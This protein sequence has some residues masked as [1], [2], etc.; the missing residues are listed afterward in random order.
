M[1]LPN[2]LLKLLPMWNYICPRCKR[3]VEKNSRRCP[4]CA[5]NYG[6][7]LRVPPKVLKDQKAL[8][9]YVHKHVFPKVS[10]WQKAYLTQFFTTIFSDGFESG[11]FSAWTGTNGSPSVVGSPVH[12]GSYSAYLDANYEKIFKDFG[13]I[14][15]VYARCYVFFETLPVGEYQ[16]DHIL[17]L[18]RN[19]GGASAGASCK[20]YNNG[21]DVR[22]QLYYL[23][24][25]FSY[26]TLTDTTG[27]PV[28]T[29]QWYC[30]ELWH[31]KSTLYGAKLWID[32]VLR[33]TATNTTCTHDIT[34]IGTLAKY[35]KFY[36]DCY[37]VADAY[38]G[39]ESGAVLKEIVDSLGLGDSVLCG[40]SFSVLDSVGVADVPLRSWSPSVADSVG[41][42]DVVLLSKLFQVFDVLGLVDVISVDKVLLVGD[43]IGLDDN[44]YVSKV[45]V[46]SDEIALV[47]V[48]EKGVAGVAKTRVFLILGDLA[49]QLCG[50]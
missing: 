11:D 42:S 41:V 35:H 33:L 20:I 47:E 2:W 25:G 32:G 26:T 22:W 50:G 38:V 28:A 29:G 40:K 23:N 12:H 34:S 4:H 36:V 24:S 49:I 19:S 39:P 21:T 1:K 27:N 17:C 44:V 13:A 16:S 18:S 31:K 45:L 14:D 7:P 46:V 3:E 37:V 9:D 43:L 5:E 6:L 8:E 48:V 10:A 15:D 30:V